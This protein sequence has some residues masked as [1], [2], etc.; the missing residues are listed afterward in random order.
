MSADVK[1][2][3]NSGIQCFLAGN[4]DQLMGHILA[5]DLNKI[6][7]EF[8]AQFVQTNTP[9]GPP[10]P[11]GKS[12]KPIEAALIRFWRTEVDGWD[13]I[14]AV[15]HDIEERLGVSATMVRKYLEQIDAPTTKGQFI[16]SQL[17]KYKIKDRR[18]A[19]GWVGGDLVDPDFAH[20]ELIELY[21]EKDLKPIP[22]K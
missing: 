11:K 5:N 21:R 15:R 18:I 6:E 1:E 8:L 22:E 17:A 4:A 12:R 7:R 20:P 16:N 13:K 3:R 19:L 10:G 2:F 14:D 9:N